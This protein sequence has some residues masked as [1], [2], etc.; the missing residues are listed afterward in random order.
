MESKEIA[1]ALR[2]AQENMLPISPIR[3]IIGVENIE[4]AY[5]IQDVN[6]SSRV[7]AGARIVGKKIGLTSKSVQAQLG[8]DQPDFGT[9]L[10]TMEVLTGQ[11][12]DANQIL[13]PKV[14]AEIAIV[15]GDDLDDDN[16]TIVDIID[17]VDYVLPS[18]E[19]VGSRILNWDIKITDTIADNASAS[20]YV[21][22]HTPKTLDE[23]DIVNCKM[24]MSKNN[25]VCSTGIGANCL[26]S[27]LNA[28]LWLAKTMVK[29]NCP[30]QAG[31][32]ILTGALGPM[33]ALENG[34]KIEADFEGLGQV[35]VHFND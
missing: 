14:E 5:E 10:D 32:V 33:V 22:G 1:Q 18:I 11:T 17:S 3:D 29:L 31:E 27:P 34:D 13:Q 35:S 9:L 15:L 28:L 8:V 30:L 24:T 4:L 26:G 2:L 12:M 20:H 16:L 21:L 25:E 23:I 6:I 7:D 19:I